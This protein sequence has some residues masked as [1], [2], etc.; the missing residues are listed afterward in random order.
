MSKFTD[1]LQRIY[2]GLTPTMGFRKTDAA[3]IPPLLIVANLAKVSATEAKAL[4]NAGIDAGIVSIKGL[5]AKSFGQLANAVNYIPL[6]LALESTETAAI[7][8]SI[9]MGCDFVVFGLKTPLEAVNKEG[10]SKVLKIE[11]SLEPGLVRAI[12]GLPLSIDAVLVTGDEPVITVER[13]L[14]YQRFAELL[15]KPLLVTLSS[16]VTVDELSGLFQAGVNGLVLPEGFSAE[17]LADLKRSAG[18][19][20]KTVKRKTRTAA[21]LPRLGGELEAGVEEEEEE[22]I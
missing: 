13:L 14:I 4:A 11:P 16:M 12:N 15:D 7:A 9:D 2:R 3:E 21:I 8:K 22:E 6:G 5:T 18:R 19:L 10:V 1:K 17:A 20:S